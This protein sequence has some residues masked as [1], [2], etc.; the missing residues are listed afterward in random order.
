MLN[1]E[2]AALHNVVKTTVLLT[3]MG[4]YAEMNEAYVAAF[5]ATGR[6][7]RRSPRPASR[8]VPSSRS[9]LGIFPP[10]GSAIGL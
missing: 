2:G 3:D 9:R 10:G 7:E 6:P 8:S 5:A 4:D 1:S